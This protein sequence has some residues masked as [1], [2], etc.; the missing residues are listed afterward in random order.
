[1]TPS[2]AP[3]LTWPLKGL[4]AIYRVL[5]Y[6]LWP[7]GLAVQLWRDARRGSRGAALKR[8]LAERLGWVSPRDDRPWWIHAVS[9]GEY[10]AVTPLLM[11]LGADQP[12]QLTVGT[13][14]ARRLAGDRWPTSYAPVDQ[15][16]VIARFLRRVRPRALV[17]VETELWP[18][19]LLACRAA[20]IPVYLANGRLS[21]RSARR[22]AWGGHWRRALLASVA[23]A[24]QNRASAR[25]FRALGAK[26]VWVSG[27]LKYDAALPH[28]AQGAAA[29]GQ[30]WRRRWGA[31]RP[32]WLL[33]S[34]HRA[35]WPLLA[36]ALPAL[37]ARFPDLLMMI[38]PRHPEQWRD[39]RPF[40]ADS[41]PNCLVYR[42]QSLPDERTRL[43]IVDSLGEL[44]D[45]YAA[46]DGAWI[47]G[48]FVNH[49]GQNPLEGAVAGI[50]LLMGPSH[51][52][53]P[54][55]GRD[56]ARVGALQWVIPANW[57][58]KV[59][60]CLENPEISRQRGE[61]GRQWVH[62]QQGASQRTAQ[63]L[64]LAL[65]GKISSFNDNSSGKVGK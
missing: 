8:A 6:G 2:S 43:F 15:A 46:S 31:E 21:A 60:Y 55:I 36:P 3:P 49:G 7:V 65:T 57:G 34:V 59:Q 56:L 32:V 20:G 18:G 22:Y 42:S 13:A 16:E 1:M 9:V 4:S 29:R 58:D 26:N 33:A 45:F 61:Q 39:F 10:R 38:A 48:S 28:D 44:A 64:Q 40:A 24:A 14:T 52:N 51:H 50:P 62:S 47:G 54:D 17:L 27:N 63:W 37:W 41:A 19:W 23:V 12:I 5:G 25:R 30:A 53:F 11:A 35:E